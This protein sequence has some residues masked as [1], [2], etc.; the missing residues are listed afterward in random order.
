LAGSAG[1]QFIN[2][3]VAT[4]VGDENVFV[5]FIKKLIIFLLTHCIGQHQD[6][7]QVAA[8]NHS[9]FLL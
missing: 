3:S 5:V 8:F 2:K 6:H 9:E 7:A 4:I 1:N